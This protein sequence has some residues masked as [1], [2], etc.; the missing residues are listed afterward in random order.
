[1]GSGWSAKPERAGVGPPVT[2]VCLMQLEARLSTFSVTN[3]GHVR[4]GRATSSYRSRQTSRSRPFRKT[5]PAK[6]L[7]G[8]GSAV[9][10]EECLEDE[11]GRVLAEHRYLWSSACAPTAGDQVRRDS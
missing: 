11:R 10:T 6:G 4:E 7:R 2:L 1:M 9:T 3:S 8:E 5:E